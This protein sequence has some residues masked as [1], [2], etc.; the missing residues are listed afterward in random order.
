MAD[1]FFLNYRRSDAEAWAD[2]VFERLR[3]Q[4]PNAAVFMDIDGHI[5]LGLPWATWL[6]SQVAACDL[7]LVLIGHTWAAEFQARSAP[8]QRDY[9]R[10]EIESALSRKIPVVPVFLGEAPIPSPG[11]LP[12][13]IRPLLELQAVRLQRTSFEADAKNLID[14]ALRSIK[15]V[16]GEAAAMAGRIWVEARIIHGATDGYFL[17]GHGKTEWFKDREDGPEMVVVPAG[18]FLMGSPPDEPERG[19]NEGPV[20]GVVIAKPFGVARHAVTN[21]QFAAFVDASSHKIKASLGERNHPAV[22][23]GWDDAEEYA[24]W[25]AQTTGQP[26]RL[27]SEAEWEY[28]ARASTWTPFWWG[29]T[30]TTEQ[31]NYDGNFTYDDGVRGVWRKSTVPV[32]TFEPNPWGLYQV[33]GNVC[34]WCEDAWHNDYRDAPADGTA[35]LQRADARLRVLRG[36]SWSGNPREL[37]AA[38]R[39]RGAVGFRD[40]RNGF[41]LGR[42]LRM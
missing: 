9:V 10:V 42:T 13:S 32:E 18:S 4:L 26:Y 19:T 29:S 35:W 34:E 3:A 11:S 40:N 38:N 12:E 36:G 39:N 17:P 33:H 30:I 28:A 20:H 21:E 5:P 25:L 8:G 6:D 15:L 24:R 27:L 16:R 37:R 7:M 1:K 41:R 23:V 22:G 14:G 2:R 31:A